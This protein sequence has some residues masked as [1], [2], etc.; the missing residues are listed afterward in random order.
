MT[1]DEYTTISDF[2]RR[3]KSIVC[4]V[5]SARNRIDFKPAVCGIE[6]EVVCGV[7]FSKLNHCDRLQ[8]RRWFDIAS[9]RD[10]YFIFSV[11]FYFISCV[12]V[13]I[14]LF[15][16]DSPGTVFVFAIVYKREIKRKPNFTD[17][18][19]DVKL[20]QFFGHFF[21]LFSVNVSFHFYFIFILCI[22]LGLRLRMTSGLLYTRLV[23]TI[24]RLYIP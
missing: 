6:F 12:I 24:I 1:I 9:R 14:Y 4:D 10:Y 13:F 19:N 2:L 22:I 3:D 8:Q 5:S 7:S 18:S 23:V 17:N 11:Y 21:S 16:F 15:Q 20:Y